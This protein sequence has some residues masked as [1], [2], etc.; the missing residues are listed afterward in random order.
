MSVRADVRGFSDLV[1]YSYRNKKD[2]QSV[3]VTVTAQTGYDFSKWGGEK[4]GIWEKKM[5]ND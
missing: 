3:Q 5:S 1:L 4:E 2:A